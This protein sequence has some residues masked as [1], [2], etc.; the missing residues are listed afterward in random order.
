MLLQSF[1]KSNKLYLA[2]AILTHFVLDFAAL[3]LQQYG[4]LWV[5]VLATIFAVGLGAYVWMTWKQNNTN[6]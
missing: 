4:I 5:E 6:T 3:A 1:V 2:G